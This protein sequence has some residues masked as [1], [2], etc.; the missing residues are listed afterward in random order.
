ME[1]FVERGQK[2]LHR[3]KRGKRRR[4]RRW[5]KRKKRRRRKRR[6][7]RSWLKYGLAILGFEEMRCF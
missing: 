3:K 2:I 1:T 7:K 6:N 4:Q 5:R